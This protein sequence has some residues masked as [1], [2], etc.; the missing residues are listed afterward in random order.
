V[1]YKSDIPDILRDMYLL[2]EAVEVGAEIIA[3]E[4]RKRVPV[5]SGALRDAIHTT[6]V[7]NFSVEVVAGNKDVFYGHLV[8][9]GGASTPPR[10]FLIPAL[11]D[12]RSKVLDVAET[13]LAR[14]VD[15]N[16]VARMIK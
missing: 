4:A 1:S 5:D 11:E 13:Y 9:Y 6:E 7:K 3:A 12:R 8:E 14:I 2:Q 10:P 16:Q 15:Q